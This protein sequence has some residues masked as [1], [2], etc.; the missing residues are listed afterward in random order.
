[1]PKSVSNTRSG[2]AAE[3]LAINTEK[4]GEAFKSLLSKLNKIRKAQRSLF[5]KCG[6]AE[7]GAGL[8]NNAYRSVIEFQD[9]ASYLVSI[10]KSFRFHQSERGNYGLADIITHCNSELE[11]LQSIAEERELDTSVDNST[12]VGTLSPLSPETE[13]ITGVHFSDIFRKNSV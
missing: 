5:E 10:K 1:M 7:D 9:L 3:E 13:G 6:E 11:S 4:Q 12:S 2:S 8:Y